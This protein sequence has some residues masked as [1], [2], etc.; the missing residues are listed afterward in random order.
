MADNILVNAADIKA[1][2][3]KVQQSFDK[4]HSQLQIITNAIARVEYEG[5]NATKFKREAGEIAAAFSK[6][7]LEDMQSIS[8]AIRVTTTNISQALGGEPIKINVNG[9]AIRPQPVKKGDGT[10]SAKTTSLQ[11]L[12][13]TIGKRCDDIATQLTSQL[14]ALRSTTWQGQGKR[15]AVELVTRFT[16]VAREHN[17][18]AKTKMTNF[19]AAQI[20][21]LDAADK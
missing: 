8:E 16:R 15:N 14:T 18:D 4:I 9:A 21:A 5:G 2:G 17:A 10:Q 3:R 11:G 19:I 12:S 1:Y 6:A 7:M 13:S 20:S